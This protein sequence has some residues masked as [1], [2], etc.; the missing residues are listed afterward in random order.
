[1]DE[2]QKMD[3]SAQSSLAKGGGFGE[4][5]VDTACGTLSHFCRNA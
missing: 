1:M 5:K 4:G 3:T 2:D